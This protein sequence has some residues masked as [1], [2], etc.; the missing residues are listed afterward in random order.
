MK[1]G[2]WTKYKLNRPLTPRER[3]ETLSREKRAGTRPGQWFGLVRFNSTYIDWIDHRFRMRGMIDSAMGLFTFCFMILSE[4]LFVSYGIYT[5]DP[6][7]LIA[8]IPGLG[9]VWLVCIASMRFELFTYTHYPI[10]F[11][12]K[13]KKVH[14]FKHNGPGGVL[15]VPWDEIVF[16]I[17]H[18]VPKDELM[19]IRGEVM[20]GDKIKETFAVGNDSRR[21]EIVRGQWEFIRAY[22]EEG[23]DAVVATQKEHFVEASTKSSWANCFISAAAGVS[24]TEPGAYLFKL[25]LCYWF[26]AT[27]WLIFKTC[28][29]PVFPS[30]V[31]KESVVAG[32]DPNKWPVPDVMGGFYNE[33]GSNGIRR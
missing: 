13:T 31:E 6:L 10:R 12:T 32:D 20:E 3:H 28:K 5:S 9:L 14:V 16:H 19:N 27:R 26:A 25:V 33:P 11:N 23:P 2:W 29:V 18:G 21:L 4:L 1:A 30:A 8:I 22:M 24:L 17:G 7:S 15:T